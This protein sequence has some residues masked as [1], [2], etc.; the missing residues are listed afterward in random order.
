MKHLSHF[1]PKVSRIR[2]LR[3]DGP[4]STDDPGLV[5]DLL[6]QDYFYSGAGSPTYVIK[7]LKGSRAW[8]NMLSAHKRGTVLCL[9]SGT[10][11]VFAIRPASCYSAALEQQGR[12]RF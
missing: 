1:A 5:D 12:G 6:T 9:G 7:H 11:P 4:Y 3:K 10:Q 2:A 8:N